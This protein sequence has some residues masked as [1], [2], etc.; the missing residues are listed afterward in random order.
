[1]DLTCYLRTSIAVFL[2]KTNKLGFRASLALTRHNQT[3]LNLF[4]SLLDCGPPRIE[5][6][7]LLLQLRGRRH[8]CPVSRC[9]IMATNPTRAF[10]HAFL[11]CFAIA[12]LNIMQMTHLSGFNALTI[13]FNDVVKQNLSDPAFPGFP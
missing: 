7:D 8:G 1:M 11:D 5:V 4:S 9:L 6:L 3:L 2:L 12:L 10:R 13:P